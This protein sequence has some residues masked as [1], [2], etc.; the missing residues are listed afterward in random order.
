MKTP[1]EVIEAKKRGEIT[2]L[3]R[4]SDGKALEGDAA[5]QFALAL[6]AESLWA[7]AAGESPADQMRKGP[8]IG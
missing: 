5:K 4:P 8:F 6:K 2:V 3:T 7:L 1:V